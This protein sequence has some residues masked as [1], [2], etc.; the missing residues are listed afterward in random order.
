MLDPR[1][2]I[3]LRKDVPRDLI[4]QIMFIL[5]YYF[6]RFYFQIHDEYRERQS[7]ENPC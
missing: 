1:Y 5:R 6:L 2:Y 7:I 3:S 4:Y